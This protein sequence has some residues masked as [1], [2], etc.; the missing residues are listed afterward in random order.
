MNPAPATASA[1]AIAKMDLRMIGSL[2]LVGHCSRPA[3]SDNDATLDMRRSGL[4]W[5]ECVADLAQ[6]AKRRLAL[7][8]RSPHRRSWPQPV[9]PAAAFVA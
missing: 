3:G 9:D 6:G 5:D 7:P 1:K 8:T 2:V 4:T